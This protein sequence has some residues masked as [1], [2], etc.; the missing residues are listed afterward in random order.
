MS[1]YILSCLIC[2]NKIIKVI[3][4]NPVK[5]WWGNPVTGIVGSVTDLYYS[6]KVSL[7][8]FDLFGL[9]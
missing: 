9:V 5:F 8:W 6:F 2:C 1:N 4:T 3:G 7:V